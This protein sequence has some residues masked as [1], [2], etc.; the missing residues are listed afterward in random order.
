MPTKIIETPRD[1]MQGISNFIPTQKK[2]AYLNALLEVGFDEMDYSSFVSP[3]A[4]PQLADSAEVI[5]KL[6][7]QNTST[8]IMAT[9]GNLRGAER[10][11]T[12]S[13]IDSVAFP[14]SIS[15]TFLQKNIRSD[16]K[17][18]AQTIKDILSLCQTKNKEL[19][20]YIAMA[21]GNPYGD[22]WSVQILQ[23]WVVRLQQMGVKTVMLADTT[24]DGSNQGIN[25]SFRM[26]SREFSDLE[27]GV[28]LHTTPDDWQEK[29]AASYEAG[30]RRFDTALGG[31]GGCPM[32]G[33]KLIGNLSTEN[34]LMF[35][36]QQ[37]E[38]LSINKEAFQKAQTL[39]AFT[40]S[41]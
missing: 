10:A 21:F 2:I 34:L 15:E 11:F 28:H 12:H 18:G 16:F 31:F 4:I 22:D 14:F 6:S 25:D 38:S 7:L 35:L 33:K 41:H 30:C 32:S 8:K 37:G 36:E 24:G 27:V 29:V 20:L 40:F 5:E 9:I 23:D 39:A 19:V 3:R 17:H 26:L 13:A 1:A